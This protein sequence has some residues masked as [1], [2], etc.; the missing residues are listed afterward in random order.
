[1]GQPF[2]VLD[3]A[4]GVSLSDLL[5][6]PHDFATRLLWAQGI[7]AGL[8]ALH[9]PD[10][11]LLR[12]EPL[13]YGDLKPENVLIVENGRAVLSACALAKVLEGDAAA[14]AV[15]DSLS[16]LPTRTQ[17]SEEPP[18]PA[19]LAQD[20]AT[21]CRAIHTPQ[22]PTPGTLAYQAPEHWQEVMPSTA[23]ADLYAFGILLSKLLTGRHALLDLEQPQSEAAWR[24]A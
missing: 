3:Y 11:D 8:L 7:A 5:A 6:L 2:L 23:A 4:E 15:L 12:P 10:P 19:A 18:T 17:S 9:T 13:A 14:L 20:A 1:S 22:G 21:R 16:A 24:P